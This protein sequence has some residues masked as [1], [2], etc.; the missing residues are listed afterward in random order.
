M[1]AGIGVD[2]VQTLDDPAGG[3]GKIGMFQPDEYGRKVE[4]SV[5]RM[6]RDEENGMAPE[7]IAAKVARLAGRRRVAPLYTVGTQYK[8]L[9]FLG[10]LLPHSLIGRVV[11]R[12]YVKE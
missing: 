5:A 10:R 9:L 2:L 1:F 7:R 4:A 11:G 12:M 6:E 3:P 8:L